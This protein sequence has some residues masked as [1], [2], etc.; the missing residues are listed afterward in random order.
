MSGLVLELEHKDGPNGHVV[1]LEALPDAYPTHFHD[2]VFWE[3]LGRTVGTFG[4]LE[5]VL[6]RAIYSFT[7]RPDPA[8]EG[9]EAYQKWLSTLKRA[10]SDPLGGLI[11]LYERAVR[12]HPNATIT[13]ADDLINDLRDASIIRNVLCHGSWQK[14]NEAG[15]SLPR[16]VNRRDEMFETKVDVAFLQ[17][18]QRHVANLAGVVVST[19]TDMGL[20]FPGSSGP[21]MPIERNV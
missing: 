9:E 17:Q 12:K 5:E 16:F 6:G 1:D 13:N 2:A 10:L 20:Q 8:F 14:P 15:A 7:P 3:W 11:E 21:G 19:V 4:F 18:V